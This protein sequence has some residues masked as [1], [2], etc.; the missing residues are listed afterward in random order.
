MHFV[1]GFGN[2]MGNKKVQGLPQT[3]E[4]ANTYSFPTN[5]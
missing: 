1:S 2:E 5:T 3:M 4:A